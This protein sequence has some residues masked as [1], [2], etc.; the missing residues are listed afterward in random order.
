MDQSSASVYQRRSVPLLKSNGVPGDA[1]HNA[2]SKPDN[3]R[4]DP[5]EERSEQSN[6]ARLLSYGVDVTS[7]SI[8]VFVS[9]GLVVGLIFGGCCSNVCYTV[10][11]LMDSK[12]IL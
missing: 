10:Q 4:V 6:L 5:R 11:K 2:T 8:P 9:W 12:V 1:L 3:D 7:A